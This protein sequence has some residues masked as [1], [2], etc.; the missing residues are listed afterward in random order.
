MGGKR[1]AP[2]LNKF[3]HATDSFPVKAGNLEVLSRVRYVITLDS[4]TQLP[5][6]SAQLLAGAISHPLNRAVIDPQTRIVTS[7]YGILQPRIGVSIQSASSSRLAAI[8]SGET[9]HRA[10]SDAYQDLYGEGI[11]TGK[12]IYEVATLHKVL[13]RRFP[14]NSLLSHDLIEG[15]YACR[16]ASDIELIDTILALSAYTRRKH[17]WVRGDWQI[18]QWLFGLRAG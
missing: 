3:L 7:G 6:G 2:D 1:V 8:Y 5:R 17:R 9:G 13:D 16:L 12:G 18:S 10:V 4:D 15:A 11:F 14:R